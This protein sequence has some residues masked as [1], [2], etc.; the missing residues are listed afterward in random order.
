[1]KDIRIMFYRAKYASKSNHRQGY[2]TKKKTENREPSRDK[3]HLTL[4]LHYSRLRRH[5]SPPC[6]GDR[7]QRW[8]DLGSV[9]R[10]LSF[11]SIVFLLFLILVLRLDGTEPPSP[12]RSPT[13]FCFTFQSSDL[14][15]FGGVLLEALGGSSIQR[16]LS[17][18][19]ARLGLSSGRRD[20]LRLR[21]FGG[22]RVW[23]F[24][25]VQV[26]IDYPIF[27]V[28]FHYSKLF[29]LK[30]PCH[31]RIIWNIRFDLLVEHIYIF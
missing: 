24:I 6:E 9:A 20:L 22:H 23:G 11:P 17:I 21:M 29:F 14:V 18:L 25:P 4:F 15:L 8:S 19:S 31:T 26:A 27:G 3:T 7:D 5:P 1:M 13:T 30:S 2:S 12:P 10:Y 28:V 16:A